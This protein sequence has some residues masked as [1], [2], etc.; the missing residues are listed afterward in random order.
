VVLLSD[1]WSDIADVRRIIAQLSSSG[2]H[3]HIVQIVDP[4]E[5][6]FPYWGR[7]EFIEPEDGRRITAGRAENWRADYITQIAQHRAAIRS[8]ADRLG[9]SFSIH[10]TDRSAAE[11]LLA[12]HARIGVG[13][14]YDRMQPQA[15]TRSAVSA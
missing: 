7:I 9:W 10:R 15:P 14:V 6:T 3:G 1:L 12:L 11:L 5:E 2:T 13:A 8:E 4:A